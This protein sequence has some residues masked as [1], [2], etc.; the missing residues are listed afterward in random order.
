MESARAMSNIDELEDMATQETDG[1]SIG[2]RQPAQGEPS[3][4]CGELLACIKLA[5]DEFHRLNI[6]YCYWKSTLRLTAALSGTSDLDLLVGRQDQHRAQAALLNLGFKLFPEASNRTQ[7]GAS[8]YLG[9]DETSG[10]LVHIDLHFRLVV[11]E[12]LLRN[13]HLPWEA[14]ILSRA[15]LHPVLPIRVLDPASEAVLWAARSAVERRRPD[16]VA[17]RHRAAIERKF[18]DERQHLSNKFD[19]H[20]LRQQARE[21]VDDGLA[22]V[23]V[24]AVFSEAPQ[25]RTRVLRGMRRQL[26]VYRAYNALE[27]RLRAVV[28]AFLLIASTVNTQILWAPRSWRRRAPG[29]GRVVALVG[30]D[31]SGKS[32]AVAAL[33]AWLGS[34]VDVMPAYFGT[35]DGRPSLLLLPMKIMV[36]LISRLVRVKPKG[37]SH[38]RVSDRSP[39]PLYSMLLMV[40]AA[41]V[42]TE[43]RIKLRAAHRGANRGLVV[44]ADR[45]PQKEDMEASDGPLLRRLRYAPLWLRR[46]E[47]RAYALARQLPPDLVLKLRI[48][49][50]TVARREPEMNWAMICQRI[51]GIHG[52]AFPGACVVEIDAERPLAEVLL[53]LKREIWNLL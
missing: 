39:G 30:V 47:E 51:K 7:I 22:D 41:A 11:G 46:Y 43:K 15:T 45:Y 37:A 2:E 28:R 29:G 13:Y 4:S 34:E 21:I 48:T 44:V 9:Y 5:L 14:V 6:S 24:N 16:P 17:L 27:A 23:V 36:P 26:K 8:T 33:R 40:W 52:L 31:G 35:G 42:A 25:V 49:P 38:G 53:H 12:P 10:R 3:E 1:H 50:D 18:D 20:S 32:T 19:R